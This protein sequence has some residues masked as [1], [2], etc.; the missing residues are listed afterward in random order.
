MDFYLGGVRKHCYTYCI[1]SPIY[2]LLG[3]LDRESAINAQNL[4]RF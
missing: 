1:A 2:F 4:N 3:Y